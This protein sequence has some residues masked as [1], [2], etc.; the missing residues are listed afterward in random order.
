MILLFSMDQLSANQSDGNENQTLKFRIFN[1]VISSFFCLF[2]S[3]SIWFIFG[4]WVLSIFKYGDFF[5]L[6]LSVLSLLSFL[7]PTV[8]SLF[9][10]LG[11]YE[12][13]CWRI[14]WT[15]FFVVVCLY[16]WM[17]RMGPE[18]LS[19][20]NNPWTL[21]N[22]DD[23]FDKFDNGILKK[24]CLSKDYK[25]FVYSLAA[26]DGWNW[27]DE[28][29]KSYLDKC[30][31]IGQTVDDRLLGHLGLANFYYIQMLPDKVIYNLEQ[32]ENLASLRGG[33][34][35][36]AVYTYAQRLSLNLANKTEDDSER[37]ELVSYS[38]NTLDDLAKL[39]ND[40]AFKFQIT[41]ALAACYEENGDYDLSINELKK[42]LLEL[43]SKKGDDLKEAEKYVNPGI[44][45]ERIA[46][47]FI[48]LG[49]YQKALDYLNMAKNEYGK[50]RLTFNFRIRELI[51]EFKLGNK[52]ECELL[53]TQLDSKKFRGEYDFAIVGLCL[54]GDERLV[55]FGKALGGE[56][57][58]KSELSNSVYEYLAKICNQRFSP[59]TF[60]PM[61]FKASE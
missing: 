2:V 14:V 60:S 57:L 26:V 24:S 48:G 6:F 10:F 54:R 52:N 17:P 44:V 19:V 59:A 22:L 41:N 28:E 7:L 51:C 30:I 37:K 12:N 49:R 18:I 23:D 25:A 55:Y 34:T 11:K 47:N 58:K 40:D 8:E 61:E 9:S 38:I 3:F 45:Y 13:L 1:Y 56:K 21:N 29:E 20:I 32:A 53:A 31:G 43:Q 36:E 46:T 50:S 5:W 16:F 15:V 42:V 27:P 33:Q 4:S 35:K 39:R